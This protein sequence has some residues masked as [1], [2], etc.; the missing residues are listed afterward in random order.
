MVGPAALAEAALAEA[1]EAAWVVEPMAFTSK[2]RGN[3]E[4]KPAM[5]KEAEEAEEEAEKEGEEEAG[6][7]AEEE[8]EGAEGGEE[9]EGEEEEDD[10]DEGEETAV[11]REHA[12]MVATLRERTAHAE[13]HAPPATQCIICFEHVEEHA[14][15][16]LPCAPERRHWLCTDCLRADVAFRHSVR[17][18]CAASNA[19]ACRPEEAQLG[20]R[21]CELQAAMLCPFCNRA[22]P[23]DA[24]EALLLE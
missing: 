5:L 15:R 8:G 6:E 16:A 10:D 17:Q 3:G 14:R 19:R 21:V 24:A 12:R 1:A 7:E 13:A 20:A 22:V 11:A 18:Q 2:E 9:E 4:R 23:A